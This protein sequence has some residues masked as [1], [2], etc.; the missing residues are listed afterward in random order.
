MDFKNIQIEH[1]AGLT[2]VRINRPQAMNALNPDVLLELAT[3]AHEINKNP[4]IKVVVITGAGDK[5]FVAGADIAAMKSMTAIEAKQFCD[6]G[7]RVMKQIQNAHKP[8]IA[9]VNGFCLGGG[10]ELALSCD[11]IYASENAKLGLPEVNLGIFPGFGG[12]QRLPRLIG[13]N[14]AKELIFTAKMLSAQEGKEWGIVN[15]V[16]SQA[17]LLKEVEATAREIM[18]KGPIAIQLAKQAVNEGTDLDINSGLAIEQALF[19]TIFSTEDKLEGISA[20][21][22]KRKAEFKGK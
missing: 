17:D 22:E 15:K 7:H 14:K 6:L 9:A 8:V 21:L 11:F 3:F 12:T 1:N 16:T 13:K 4:E 5:A 2:T 19:P 10:L 20:F 18:K